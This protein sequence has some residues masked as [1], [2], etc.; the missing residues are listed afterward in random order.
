MTS[1]FLTTTGVF[2]LCAVPQY[3]MVRAAYDNGWLD[4]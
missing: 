3:L 4:E 2:A 1:L